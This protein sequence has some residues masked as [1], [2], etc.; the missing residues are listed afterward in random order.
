VRAFEV[1]CG[2]LFFRLSSFSL[3][4]PG[5]EVNGFVCHMFSHHDLVLH[6]PKA[7]G[8]THHGLKPQ[9]YELKLTFALYK[10]II[11]GVCCRG[12]K[13]TQIS[14]VNTRALSLGSIW[15]N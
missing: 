10:L 14:Q 15:N 11:S 6:R 5:H 7:T 12:G 8:P 2:S 1:D 13:L 3:L 4:L 9:N